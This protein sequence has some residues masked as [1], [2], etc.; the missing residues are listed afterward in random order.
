MVEKTSEESHSLKPLQSFELSLFAYEF[1]AGFK[2]N[3]LYI[4]DI[5]CHKLKISLVFLCAEIKETVKEQTELY[6]PKK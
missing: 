1:C 4:E 5:P 3:L 2:R 6:H